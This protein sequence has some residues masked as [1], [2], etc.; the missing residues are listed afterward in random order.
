MQPNVCQDPWHPYLAGLLEVLGPQGSIVTIV[1][2]RAHGLG[3]SKFGVRQS[4]R[5][6]PDVLSKAQINPQR[7]PWM[8][9]CACLPI[10]SF[11]TLRAR[12]LRL[13]G[14]DKAHDKVRL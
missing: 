12:G 10:S 13:Q 6:E 7:V 1:V 14:T 5:Q 4:Q 2:C 9:D 8:K 11:F 3:L